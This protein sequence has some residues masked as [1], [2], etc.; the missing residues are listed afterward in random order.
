MGVSGALHT[1]PVYWRTTRNPHMRCPYP[2]VVHECG[3]HVNQLYVRSLD[4]RTQ[5]LF[6]GH[7]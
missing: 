5:T 6:R 4:Q 1:I 3:Q 7:L 2:D